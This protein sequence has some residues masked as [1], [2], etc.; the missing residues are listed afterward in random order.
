MWYTCLCRPGC[1]C[2]AEYSDQCYYRAEL[3]KIISV[4]PAK[5]LIHHVDFG[6]DDMLQTTK[7][8]PH[9]LKSAPIIAVIFRG[10]YWEEVHVNHC[11][12]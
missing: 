7:Y 11:V 9:T 4:E 2:L 8:V 3:I 1:L 6:S 12:S 5:V 10:K